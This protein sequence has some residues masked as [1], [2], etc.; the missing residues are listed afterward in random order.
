MLP[1]FILT[2]VVDGVARKFAACDV[3]TYVF[4]FAHPDSFAGTPCF[5]EK[6]EAGKRAL[7][8]AHQQWATRVLTR[9]ILSP[10]LTP[11]LVHRLGKARE[12]LGIA[13]QTAIGIPPDP[14]RE[15]PP[16]ELLSHPWEGARPWE[17]EAL[18]ARVAIPPPNFR[19]KIRLVAA[20]GRRP[21][22]EVWSMPISEWAFTWHVAIEDGLKSKADA[23]PFRRAPSSLIN[24]VGMDAG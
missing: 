8:D 9:V 24:L 19:D 16:A 21:H 1:D 20:K 22:W 11:E 17:R 6:D 14:P 12:D 4:F 3:P 23:P 10:A 18:Q 7:I 13:Y 2:V 5:D 15:I